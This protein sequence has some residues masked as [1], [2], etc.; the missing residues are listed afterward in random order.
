MQTY[1][2]HQRCIC[3]NSTFSTAQDALNSKLWESCVLAMWLPAINLHQRALELAVFC[4]AA[5]WLHLRK[6]K[7]CYRSIKLDIMEVQNFTSRTK[8]V[9]MAGIN[10]LRS[11]SSGRV[12]HN[13]FRAMEGLQQLLESPDSLMFAPLPKAQLCCPVLCKGGN[14]CEMLPTF[15]GGRHPFSSELMLSSDLNFQVSPLVQGYISMSL[16]ASQAPSAV[17]V[18]GRQVIWWAA[19]LLCL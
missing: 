15:L 11:S 16:Q 18:M 13:S 2:M 10:R 3:F 14:R 7:N 19:I 1:G 12:S 6:V 4:I 8:K 17:E 9:T 5:N